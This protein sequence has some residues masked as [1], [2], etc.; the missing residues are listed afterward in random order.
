MPDR[1]NT[2]ADSVEQP[3]LFFPDAVAHPTESKQTSVAIAPPLTATSVLG[4]CALPYQ[5]YLRLTD[6]S[7]YTITCFLSDLR[8]LTE[9]LGRETAPAQHHEGF[10]GGLAGASTLGT[11]HPT[12]AEDDGAA[13]DLPE[14]LLW[15]AG[16]GASARR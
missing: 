7:A 10:A 8:L 16:E 15:L 3:S 14:K 1:D 4:A 6:H 2:S 11:R 13:S 5:E 12:G 9:F